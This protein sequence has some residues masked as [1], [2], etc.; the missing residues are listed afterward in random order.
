MHNNNDIIYEMGADK[1]YIIGLIILIVFL[2]FVLSVLAYAFFTSNFAKKHIFHQAIADKDDLLENK[3]ANDKEKTSTHDFT[4][5][6]D[7]H[8][9]Q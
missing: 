6:S 3:F 8:V 1:Q 7:E 4:E 2:V 9:N 5:E